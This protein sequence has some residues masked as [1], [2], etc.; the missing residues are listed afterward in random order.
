M[1]KNVTLLLL[2]LFT[3]LS[4]SQKKKVAVVSF[5]TDKTIDFTDLGIGNEELITSIANLRDNPD[6]NLTPILEKFH[7]EFFNE[8]SKK[9]PFE[10]LPEEEVLTNAAYIKFQPKWDKSEEELTRYIVYDGYKYIYEGFLGKKNE[11]GMANIFKEN[12][13]GVL[14]VEIHF[15][16][17]KGFGIGGTASIKMKAYCRMALYNKDGKKV[18]AINESAKSKKTAVMV[19]GI[20]AMSPKKILPMCESA[21]DRLMKHLDKRLKKIAK[22]ADKK[23]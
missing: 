12:A 15:S 21:L 14:F 7:K 8:Y 3:S 22:K 5:Y 6:F 11:E 4:F 17:V 18:F 19:G 16:L 20:P 9:F 13:D 1:K 10:L 23:L 2:I